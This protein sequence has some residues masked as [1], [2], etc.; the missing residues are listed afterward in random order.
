MTF[1]EIV[2]NNPVIVI[3]TVIALVLGIAVNVIKLFESYKKLSP[4]KQAT[5]KRVFYW[6]IGVVV[7]VAIAVAIGRSGVIGKIKDCWDS[8]PTT[9]KAL[10]MD[11]STTPTLPTTSTTT[12][13][14]TTSSK[15]TAFDL[16]GYEARR[17]EEA[18]RVVQQAINYGKSIGLTY[19]SESDSKGYTAWIGCGLRLHDNQYDHSEDIKNSFADAIK[20]ASEDRPYPQYFTVEAKPYMFTHVTIYIIYR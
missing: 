5:I 15:V 16:E 17:K 7:V 11:E 20:S 12:T 13:T 10:T 1:K 8:R 19:V 3:L 4:K 14:T 9:T 2:E 6:T 18:D